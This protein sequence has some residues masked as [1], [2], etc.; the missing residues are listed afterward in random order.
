MNKEPLSC[1]LM[2]YLHDAMCSMRWHK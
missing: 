2:V 1:E